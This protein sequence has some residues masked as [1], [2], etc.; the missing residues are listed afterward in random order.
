MLTAAVN[1]VMLFSSVS[2]KTLQFFE[3]YCKNSH[4]KHSTS[5]LLK[6]DT[7]WFLHHLQMCCCLLWREWNDWSTVKRS[8]MDGV[9]F[10]WQYSCLCILRLCEIR[11]QR[12]IL[13]YRWLWLLFLTCGWAVAQAAECSGSRLG[14][15]ELLCRDEMVFLPH[16]VPLP[17]SL[18]YPQL[19]KKPKEPSKQQKQKCC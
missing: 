7:L 8:V 6:W 18:F 13:R 10:H 5:C 16:A 2:A 3:F 4:F 14:S 12:S 9:F 11:F 17:M 19:V 15:A 1:L